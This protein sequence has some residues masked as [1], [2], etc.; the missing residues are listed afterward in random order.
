MDMKITFS[1]YF[2]VTFAHLAPDMDTPE[3]VEFSKKQQE[4][5]MLEKELQLFVCLKKINCL[6]TKC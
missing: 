5:D 2:K 1:F 3:L 4:I 6:A